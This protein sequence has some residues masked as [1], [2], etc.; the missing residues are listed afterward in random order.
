MHDDPKHNTSCDDPYAAC[1]WAD[2]LLCRA[3]PEDYIKEWEQYI[4]SD[5]E[6]DLPSTLVPVVIFRIVDEYL[7]LP[8]ISIGQITEMKSI[9]RLPHQRGKILKG[10][11]NM[12]G[13]L[14]LFI[15]L[16]NLLELGDLF[17][18][19]EMHESHTLLMI[20]EEGE[21][22][23]FAVSEVCGLHH[24]DL[25]RLKNT[26]VTVSKSTANYLKGVFYWGDRSV[27]LLEEELLFFSLRRSIL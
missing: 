1:L 13:Q 7:A 2:K 23:V 11:V 18:G 3:A 14:R 17:K 25:A 8:T 26:P 5:Q 24:C 27:G 4:A 9:H 20:Q 12:N 6:A 15:S 10:L 19:L 21:V 22:W 16:A